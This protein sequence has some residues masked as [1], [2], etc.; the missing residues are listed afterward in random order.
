MTRDAFDDLVEEMHAAEG[1]HIW[2]RER[3]TNLVT[4]VLNEAAQ[5]LRD[6]GHPEAADLIARE[7]VEEPDTKRYRY[8]S[9]PPKTVP[10]VL[11]TETFTITHPAHRPMSEYFRL[12][13]ART[14]HDQAALILGDEYARYKAA[15]HSDA[16]VVRF[17]AS[18]GA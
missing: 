15:G 18:L 9:A 17:Y 8:K 3:A 12:R 16:D 6:T 14:A 13:K 1:G 4:S 2:T 7:P 10:L 11:G 5:K